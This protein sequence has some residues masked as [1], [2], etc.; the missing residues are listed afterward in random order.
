MTLPVVVKTWVISPNNRITFVSLTDTMANYLFGVKEFLKTNGYT[1]RG[2]SDGSAAALDLAD[3][4]ITSANVTTR[5]TVA[6]A[7]QSWIV[8]RDGNG[9][10]ILLTY[11]GTAA[12]IA[13]ISFS[14]GQL[15]VIAGTPTH[16]PTATDE[17]V[18]TSAS[19]LINTNTNT[20]RIWNGWVTSDR[21]F[22]RFN[23]ARAGVWVGKCWG[24]ENFTHALVSPAVIANPV[25]GFSMPA[26]QSTLANGSIIGAARV[27]VSAV[28]F[29]C[30][31]R[32]GA[33]FLGNNPTNASTFK[34]ELQGQW[35]IFPLSIAS[36]TTGARGK[37]GNCIDQWMGRSDA[38]DGSYYGQLEF[39]GISGYVG[40][41]ASGLWP[42]N[43][44]TYP[45]VY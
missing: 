12:E 36:T 32:Y 16:Q 38:A 13:R 21:K 28:G 10:D 14:P 31:V 30:V 1:V 2:S 22:C 18:V 8:L 44:V 26:Q 3:R 4:W 9:A 19:E 29:N 37:L 23:I 7:P 40:A 24:I 45:V 27:T 34:P 11:Q 33:E 42:W 41:G 17:Q 25:F 43:G 6:A 20:D 5:G 15:F 35:L 39:L